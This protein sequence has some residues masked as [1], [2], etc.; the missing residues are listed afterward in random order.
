MI[1]QPVAIHH[2][3]RFDVSKVEVWQFTTICEGT[4]IGDGVVIGANCWIGRDC[5]IGAR[6]RL[7]SFVF[8][9]NGTILGEDVF[10]G[11]HVAFTD[12]RYPR[13]G[14]A[15]DAQPP[16]IRRG[17]SIG[18]GAVILPGVEIGENCM[19][20]AGA[21]VTSNV[22]AGDVAYGMPARPKRLRPFSQWPRLRTTA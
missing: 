18:A 20:G 17:A 3:L 1:H 9:P 4:V 12:D 8:L 5:T 7:Q 13:A 21:V 15:Y 6:S 16:I 10:I 11:P 22:D 2:S 19:I 14:V